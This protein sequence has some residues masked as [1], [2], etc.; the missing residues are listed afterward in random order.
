MRCLPV[1]KVTIPVSLI[2]L[3]SLHTFAISK[4]PSPRSV[5][6]QEWC[7]LTDYFISI[8]MSV[9]LSYVEFLISCLLPIPCAFQPPI[10]VL[11]PAPACFPAC[12]CSRQELFPLCGCCD[13]EEGGKDSRRVSQLKGV[14]CLAPLGLP[15]SVGMPCIRSSRC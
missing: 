7:L 13:P 10:L 8:F 1:V 3:Q 12:L 15:C 4:T 9:I 5:Q 2:P 6:E 11:A 14:A